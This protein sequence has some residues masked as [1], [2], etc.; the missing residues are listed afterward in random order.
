MSIK[1]YGADVEFMKFSAGEPHVKVSN[2]TE[3]VT[4]DW[5][6][7]NFEEFISV[8]MIAEV[9]SRFTKEVS[10]NLPYVPFARQDRATSED[11]PFSLEVFAKMLQTLEIDTILTCD[12]HSCVLQEIFYD[13]EIKVYN[14]Y[15]LQCAFACMPVDYLMCAYTPYDCIISPDK[16]AIRKAGNFASGL[17]VPLVT[18]TKSRDP[19]TGQ[20]SNPQIDFGDLKPKRA[21]IPDD[22][23]DKGGTFIQLA[24]VIKQQFPEIILDLYITHGIFAAG[25]EELDKRFNQIFVY[26]DMSKKEKV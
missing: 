21:L 19:L 14:N 3:K 12:L 7:E 24:D 4:I 25:R 26:N 18:A 23:L 22:I 15:Q 5:N 10:L 13:S 1:V 9:A 20:L 8:A 2:V 17:G 16:G 6:F 11:Q